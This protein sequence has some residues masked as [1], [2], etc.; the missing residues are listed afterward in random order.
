MK[1]IKITQNSNMV[2]CSMFPVSFVWI[3]QFLVFGHIQDIDGYPAHSYLGTMQFN[4]LDW[5][6]NN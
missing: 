4:I 6:L 5:F 1:N 3:C 2:V